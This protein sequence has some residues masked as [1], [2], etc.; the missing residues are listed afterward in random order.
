MKFVAAGL[1]EDLDT[2]E[3]QLV[4][5]RRKRVLVDPDLADG[6]LGRKLAAAEPIDEDRAAIGSGSRAGECLEIGREVVGI[7]GECVQIGAA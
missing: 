5:L 6:V 1:G 7:V 4:V 2:A 3:A